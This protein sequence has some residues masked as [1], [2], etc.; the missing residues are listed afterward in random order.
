ML[1]AEVIATTA[2]YQCRY[3][4]TVMSG[5]VFRWARPGDDFEV[6]AS[7]DG[8]LLSGHGRI[9]DETGI[10]TLAYLLGVAQHAYH[11]LAAN[12]RG[13]EAVKAMI[14]RTP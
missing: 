3:T 6:S 14:R 11:L 5:P 12:D 9:L 2:G 7:R 4:P 13:T 10:A 8:V 1:D